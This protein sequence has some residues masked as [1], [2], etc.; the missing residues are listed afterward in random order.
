MRIG[1]TGG[2]GLIGTNLAKK[3]SERSDNVVIFSR[4]QSFTQELIGNNRY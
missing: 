2:T 3:L 4:K 1:I